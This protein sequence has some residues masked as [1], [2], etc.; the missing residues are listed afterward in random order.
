MCRQLGVNINPVSG[1]IGSNN[2]ATATTSTSSSSNMAKKEKDRKGP[3]PGL[4]AVWITP[5]P[6][7]HEA[8]AILSQL[9]AVEI[10]S[11]V[12]SG[13]TTDKMKNGGRN[14]A[15]FKEYVPREG[16]DATKSKK[17][18]SNSS[19]KHMELTAAE[20]EAEASRSA[21]VGTKSSEGGKVRVEAVRFYVDSVIVQWHLLL[22]NDKN[23]GH[24][25][26]CGSNNIPPEKKKIIPEYVLELTPTTA[27]KGWTE[28]YRGTGAA[29]QISGLEPLTQYYCRLTVVSHPHISHSCVVM[30]TLGTPS[31]LSVPTITRWEKGTASGSV[32]GLVV[33]DSNDLPAGCF[34][35]IEASIGSAE[36][37]DRH[38]AQ[39]WAPAARTKR[40]EVWIVGP[41]SGHS[42][43]L[44]TRIINQDGQPG[45]PSH[46]GVCQAP[47]F[48]APS[49]P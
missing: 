47:S 27:P 24:R 14:K 43:V 12:L 31:I 29:A 34:L 48:K 17:N 45:P 9:S 28:V 33:V 21:P 49:P 11:T 42:V 8:L 18:S 32:R 15:A 5:M 16:T 6:S 40:R 30:T 3:P 37:R 13:T 25:G 44:R 36:S 1:V 35:Q 41:Y 46:M 2:T 7:Q 23:K 19:R 39:E 38:A 10:S 26:V 20:K 22:D 4:Y